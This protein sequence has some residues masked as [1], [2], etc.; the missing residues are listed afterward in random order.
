MFSNTNNGNAEQNEGEPK[1]KCPVSPI[2]R[3]ISLVDLG[4]ETISPFLAVSN[5]RTF[6]PEVSGIFQNDILAT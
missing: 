5:F 3:A 4:G 1:V 6:C 2:L